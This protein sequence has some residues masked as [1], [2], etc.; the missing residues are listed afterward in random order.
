MTKYTTMTAPDFIQ[1]K[2][3]A[4]QRHD[5]GACAQGCGLDLVA[6]I[7]QCADVQAAAA[8]DAMQALH[9]S[10]RP[11]RKRQRTRLQVEPPTAGEAEGP[12]TRDLV[13]G[14]APQPGAQPHPAPKVKSHVP[15]SAT[16]RPATQGPGVGNTTAESETL[17][18]ARAYNA[19]FR[20]RGDETHAGRGPR[21]GGVR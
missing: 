4:Q 6:W 7:V 12:P 14:V 8:I 11:D 17:R 13:K 15:S 16:G 2:L 18:A 1:I 21:D 20:R 3:S 10:P 9:R 5:F 19:S